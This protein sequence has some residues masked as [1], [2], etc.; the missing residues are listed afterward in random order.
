MHLGKRQDDP[1][2][3]LTWQQQGLR[4]LKINLQRANQ[5]RDEENATSIVNFVICECP[6]S[7]RRRNSLI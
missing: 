1:V 5:T 7:R 2:Q 3:S 6:A 4:T